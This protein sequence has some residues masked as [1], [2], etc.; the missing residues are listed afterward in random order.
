MKIAFFECFSG[1]SGDMILGALTDLGLDLNFLIHELNKL[2]LSG[3]KLSSSKVNRCGISGTKFDVTCNSAKNN[4]DSSHSS[5]HKG[6]HDIC[7]II[8]DSSLSDDV[9]N[10]SLS[11]FRR[12]ADAEAKVHGIEPEDVHFHEVG[13]IDSII[14]IVGSVIG[15]R[16]LEFD[17]IFF[18]P[19][20][21]GSGC[22]ECEHGTLPVPAPATAELL[23][24]YA[25]FSTNIKRELTTPT[26]AAILT[27]LGKQTES[28]PG[29]RFTNIGY[30]AGANDNPG[31]PNLLRVFIGEKE[32]DI[33]YNT[34][35]QST[36]EVWMVETNIDDMPGEMFGY[37]IDKLLDAGAVDAYMT[38]IQMKKS[39]PSVLVSAIVPEKSL[40]DIESIFFDES[41][42]F[43]IRKYKV[44]RSKLIREI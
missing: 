44:Q 1:I 41:T 9:K 12:I 11:V 5:N 8:N 20:A 37:L 6:L 33:S 21:T 31:L 35:G 13:A 14:D 39:R 23:N 10:S 38:A 15:F 43:G 7:K 22:V 16:K 27:T 34:T 28:F 26:G 29:F 40:P 42:T 24:G 19:V 2:D 18:S 25:L 30:G 3:Y 4:H 36:D 17:A 32:S